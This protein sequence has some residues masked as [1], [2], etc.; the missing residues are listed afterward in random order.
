MRTSMLAALAVAMLSTSAQA[1]PEVIWQTFQKD[2]GDL[3]AVDIVN[4]R[5][6]SAGPLTLNLGLPRHVAIAWV[7]DAER[8]KQGEYA[9]ACPPDIPTRLIFDCEG[10][11]IASPYN[12]DEFGPVDLRFGRA[13]YV[14]G[15]KRKM[16][17]AAPGSPADKISKIA[18][19][20]KPMTTTQ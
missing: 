15:D 20:H 9:V 14:I 5:N 18:C 3:V 10:Y 13:R 16:M 8:T 7:C 19:S 17:F 12:G 6:V 4:I 1:D 11:F 2:D